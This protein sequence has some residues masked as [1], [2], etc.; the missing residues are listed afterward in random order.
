MSSELTPIDVTIPKHLANRINKPS[1]VT[2]AVSEG[3]PEGLSFPRLTTSGTRWKVIKAGAEKVLTDAA[4]LDVIVVGAAPS[5]SKVFYDGKYDPNAVDKQPDCASSN[6][7]KPNVGVKNQQAPACAACPKN[8][9]GS[10]TSDDGKMLKACRDVKIL[11]V[12]FA[13]DPSNEVWQ[14]RVSP[15]ALKN[16]SKYQKRLSLSGVPIECVVTRLSFDEEVTYPLVKFGFLEAVSES[17]M[18]QVDQLLGSTQV[19]EVTREIDGAVAPAVDSASTAE[20]DP[21]EPEAEKPAPKKE[22]KRGRGRPPKKETAPKKEPAEESGL[23]FLDTLGS[24]GTSDDAEPEEDQGE[25][26]GMQNLSAELQ[27]LLGNMDD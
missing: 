1:A 22:K 14:F 17:R 20:P 10:D 18:A 23:G 6:G 24:A 2:A 8:E 5:I 27:E 19:K 11:A 16:L 9:W 25:D 13:Q 7:I 15:A 21:A 12:T 4:S 26:A 3:L